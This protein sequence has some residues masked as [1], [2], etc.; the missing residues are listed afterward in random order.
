[1]A[2]KILSIFIDESGDFGKFES[3]CPFYLVTMILHD[4]S[5][6]INEL[7][8]KFDEHLC[9]AGFPIHA[10]HS[11]PLIRRESDLYINLEREERRFLF[12]ALFNFARKLDF[13]FLCI[14]MKK[15]PENDRI[16]FTS[17]L[18]NAIATKIREN[19]NLWASFDKIIIYYDNGQMELT[20][21]LTAV[22]SSLLDHVE[23]RKVKPVDYKLFQIADMV[24]TLKLLA[25]KLKYGLQFTK[26]EHDFFET[27]RRLKKNYL[28]Y[29]EKKEI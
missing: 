17:K 27:S 9:N 18:S 14:Q 19:S 2:A 4:Q 24:C 16:Q 1:M 20:K 11:G 21:I 25:L 5:H 28:K 12:N 15:S 6:D 26:S 22:F 10:V 3:H 29:I 23:F 8:S 13:Q 7:V